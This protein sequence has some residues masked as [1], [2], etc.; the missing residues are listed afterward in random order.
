M[1][2]HNKFFL[3]VFLIV[4]FFICSCG[5]PSYLTSKSTK[6]GSNGEFTIALTSFYINATPYSFDSLKDKQLVSSSPSL[7]FFYT[8]TDKDTSDPSIISNFNSL[9]SSESGKPKSASISSV[10]T[11]AVTYKNSD[12]SLNL[13]V[14]KDS[15][16]SWSSEF[17]HLNRT[18]E[19]GD[20]ATFSFKII[21]NKSEQDEAKTIKVIYTD[22]SGTEKELSLVRYNG[23]GFTKLTNNTDYSYIQ[24]DSE[25][26]CINVY[27]ALNLT[28]SNQADFTNRFWSDLHYLKSFEL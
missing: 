26:Y 22:K 13:Y 5:I 24:E 21:D 25:K 7:T 12:K 17:G 16:T 28:G 10:S 11:P 3:A 20:D 15:S 27:A 8:I 23:N 1:E 9:Y 18:M 2:R 6:T 19:I 14:M 4:L